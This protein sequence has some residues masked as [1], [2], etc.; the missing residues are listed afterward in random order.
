MKIVLFLGH[1]AHFHLFKH[2]IK[3]L[4]D[5]GNQVDILIKKKDI[6]EELLVRSG[7]KHTNLLPEGRRDGKLG[8]IS[9]V[10]KKNIGLYKFCKKNRPDLMIGTSAEIAH[11]G[12]LL[13]IPSINFNEDDVSVIR[14]FAAVTYPMVNHIMSPSVCNND[15]WNEKT[16]FYEGYQKLAYLHPNYFQP[17]RSIV[18]KYISTDKPYFIIR[19]AKLTAHHDDGI[20]GINDDIARELIEV[21]KNH[22]NVFISAERS[23]PNEFEQYRL[24]INPLDIHHFLAFAKL[25]VGDSQSMA[26]EAAML[27]TPSIR[28]SDFTGRVGVLEELEHKYGL[29][30][31]VRPDNPEHLY[32]AA[33][34]LLNTNDLCET[35]NNRRN[36]MLL[37]KIDVTAFF[38]WFIGNYPESYLTVKADP[39]YQKKFMNDTIRV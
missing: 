30:F 32:E 18:Q 39:S 34:N 13:G 36:K 1:P 22:G 7:I 29:T 5:N 10:V 8:I 26:V 11:V 25:Y 35:F 9:G 38:S 24:K 14:S 2:T 12:K 19:L 37:E 20:K 21:L 23:L 3:Y 33:Q 15:K 27:G 28:F 17:D 4:N 31:G 6:L 16:I